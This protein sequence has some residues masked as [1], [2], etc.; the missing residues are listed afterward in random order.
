[1]PVFED[2]ACTVCGCVCDDLRVTVENGRITEA[3]G[4]CHLSEEWFLKQDSQQ[5]PTA[6][7][8]G[9]EVLLDVAVERAA[10]ILASAKW[11]LIYGLSRSSTEGQR[12]AVYLAEKIGANIDTHL[13]HSS[14]S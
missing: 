14:A 6:E 8:D 2:V 9:Q 4:A 5:P 7:I 1:M 11:P 3:V 10:E 13:L 12:A